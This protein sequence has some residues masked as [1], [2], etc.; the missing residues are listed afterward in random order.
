MLQDL[1]SWPTNKKYRTLPCRAAAIRG[2]TT[3]RSGRREIQSPYTSQSFALPTVFLLQFLKS[4]RLQPGRA[5]L[6]SPSESRVGR[7]T[8]FH[9][10]E[11]ATLSRKA[12]P[13]DMV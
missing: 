13:S 12:D 3:G 2:N 8:P 7:E 6:F 5:S 11:T 10:P 9:Y 4:T 1:G